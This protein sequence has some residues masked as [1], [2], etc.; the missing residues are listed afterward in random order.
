VVRRAGEL[1]GRARDRRWRNI[2]ADADADAATEASGLDRLRLAK[3]PAAAQGGALE[4]IDRFEA[5]DVTDSDNPELD[6]KIAR[7]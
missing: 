2:R 4:L 6:G 7:L 3:P 5:F 1:P